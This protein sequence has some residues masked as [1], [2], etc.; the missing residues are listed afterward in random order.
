MLKPESSDIES[1]RNFDPLKNRGF[2]RHNCCHVDLMWLSSSAYDCRSN[3]V[4]KFVC[5]LV[6]PSFEKKYCVGRSKAVDK[7]IENAE[8]YGV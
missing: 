6:T 7:D 4:E 5:I 3:F 2:F 8:S 1:K